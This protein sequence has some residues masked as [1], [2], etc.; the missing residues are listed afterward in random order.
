MGLFG[1]HIPPGEFG[2]AVHKHKPLQSFLGTLTIRGCNSGAKLTGV[3]SVQHV[4]IFSDFRSTLEELTGEAGSS[5]MCPGALRR[6]RGGLQMSRGSC[7]LA[8]CS[9]K[10]T[11]RRLCGRELCVKNYIGPA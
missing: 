11:V 10:L 8:R 2:Y 7:L 3:P 6:L 1:Q 9:R 4:A 5:E